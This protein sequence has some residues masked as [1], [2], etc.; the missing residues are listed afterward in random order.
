LKTVRNRN[1][2]IVVFILG[3]GLLLGATGQLQAQGIDEAKAARVKAG[4][5]YHLTH[6]VTWPD[7]RFKDEDAPMLVAFVGK[8]PNGLAEYFEKEAK[9]FSA[10]GRRMIVR[11]FPSFSDENSESLQELSR[12][13]ILF[14]TESG[15]PDAVNLLKG[16]H[17]TSVL[18]AGETH[19]LLQ[20]GG[21]IGFVIQEGR[22]T[23]RVN[24]TAVQQAK[25]KIS[26]EFLQ[27][28]TIVDSASERN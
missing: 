11:R 1:R 16:M 3:L 21:M 14:I 17:S 4:V 27:H 12:C 22:I 20:S 19:S 6:L 8:D 9:G 10:Q 24:L 15:Q 28:A 18:V 25:L 5:L 2:S 13:H 7:E 23:I 26:A